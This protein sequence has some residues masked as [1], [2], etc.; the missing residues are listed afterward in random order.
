MS[1]AFRRWLGRGF[2]H[3][4]LQDLRENQVMSILQRM[5]KT[6]PEERAQN[7]FDARFA[8]LVPVLHN[9]DKALDFLNRYVHVR[10]TYF[11]LLR[12]ADTNLELQRRLCRV[13]YHVYAGKHFLRYQNLLFHYLKRWDL[14]P[15][16]MEEIAG[17]E[18]YRQIEEMIRK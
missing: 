17:D 7:C 8:Q 14:H 5:D 2:D 6:N 1:K 10:N 9:Y 4:E 11:R 16:V 12:G 15:K 3:L 18:K 13:D